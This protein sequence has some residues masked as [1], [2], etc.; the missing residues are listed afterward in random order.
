MGDPLVEPQKQMRGESFSTVFAPI[1]LTLLKSL[2]D[3]KGL[4]A[5]ESMILCPSA[6]PIR[7]NVFNSTRVALFTF[8]FPGAHWG[9]D[10]MRSLV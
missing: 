1:P 9:F 4:S 7:G 6:F 5:L 10:E 3:V 8:T 2:A